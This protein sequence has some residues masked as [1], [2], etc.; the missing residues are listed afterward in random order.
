[1]TLSA[2]ACCTVM[3]FYIQVTVWEFHHTVEYLISAEVKQN[4]SGFVYDL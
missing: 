3:C 1:M 4:Q 2:A